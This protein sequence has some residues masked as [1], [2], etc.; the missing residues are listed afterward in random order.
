MV[1]AAAHECGAVEV[2]EKESATRLLA[3]GVEFAFVEVRARAVH[4]SLILPGGHK[5]PGI[6]KLLSG[7]RDV[8]RHRVRVRR[9]EDVDDQLRA[10][11]CEAYRMAAS[12]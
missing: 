12:T 2:E 11:L 8:A 3:N 6:V 5:V 10:W 4:L 1:L 9:S 7:G